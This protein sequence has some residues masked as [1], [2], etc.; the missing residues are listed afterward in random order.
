MVSTIEN[1]HPDKLNHPD[2]TVPT[3]RKVHQKIHST[4][5]NDSPISINYRQYHKITLILAGMRNYSIGF[6]KDFD[7]KPKLD[8][9]FFEIQKRT[10]AYKLHSLLSKEL[11]IIDIKG[12]GPTN[13]ACILT[14][15]HPNKFPSLRKY[16]FYCG[17]T[18]RNKLTVNYCHRIKPTMYLILDGIMRKKD[19]KYYPIY[20]KIKNE[21]LAKF[22]DENFV[23]SFQEAHSKSKIYKKFPKKLIADGLAR[24]R[25]ST[26]ILKE[27]Y[28]KLHEV[29]SV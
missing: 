14:F 24:N 9:S 21:W 22:E 26:L 5:P 27:V 29:E 11:K 4:E 3:E 15:A 12:F 1:H 16:L 19:P 20:I 8:L 2:F 23:K 6:E 28:S 7:I 10:I 18:S 17:Y 25:V 13:L